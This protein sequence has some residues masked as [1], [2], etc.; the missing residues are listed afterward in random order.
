MALSRVAWWPGGRTQQRRFPV[1]RQRGIQWPAMATAA[2][3]A[4]FQVCR[5]MEVSDPPA[6][7]RPR[8]HPSSR[9]QSVKA[10]HGGNASKRLCA[11]SM[12]AKSP[13][14][15]GASQ[16]S[17]AS[18]TPVTQQTVFDG[19]HRPRTFWMAGPIS[20]QPTVLVKNNPSCPSPCLSAGKSGVTSRHAK[21]ISKSNRY[22]ISLTR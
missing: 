14:D 7:G 10:A 19:I 20:M 16:R 3:S 17:S 11:S 8:L 18:A 15:Q 22:W 12:S 2:R 6:V 13:G 9:S 4:A 1:P 21:R 5:F